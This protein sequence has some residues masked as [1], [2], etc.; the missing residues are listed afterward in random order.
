MKSSGSVTYYTSKFTS[1]V[2]SEFFFE[3]TNTGTLGHIIGLQRFYNRLHIFVCDML[4]SVWN[5]FIYHFAL[6]L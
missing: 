6:K 3:F 5:W 4:M 1:K 2:L